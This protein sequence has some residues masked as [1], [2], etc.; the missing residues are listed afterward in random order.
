MTS[1]NPAARDVALAALIAI[2]KEGAYS[3]HV[4]QAETR[5]HSLSARDEG[6]VWR[7]VYG[8][9]TYRL[10]LDYILNQFCRKKVNQLSPVLRNLLRLA[11]YQL[12]YLDRIPD[13]AAVNEAVNRARKSAGPGMAGFVNGVLRNVIRNRDGLFKDLEP[14]TISEISLRHSHPQWMVESWVQ[15]WGSDFTGSLC[16]ANNR[17]GPLTVR[18]NT[19]KLSV[20]QFL[21]AAQEAGLEGQRGRCSDEA[22]VFAGDT[23]FSKLPGYQEG[24]FIVQG[25]ASMLPAL[26]LDVQPGQDVLDMCSAPGG[27]TTQLAQLAYSG[28]VVACDLHPS[29]LK[30]VE[31]NARRLG[32]GNIETVLGDAAFLD[33]KLNR[34]FERILVDAPCS[35]LG[36]I[37]NKPDIK[38]TRQPRD[39]EELAG[40]QLRILRAGCNLLKPGGILV[41]ST[42]TISQAENRGV[43]H[44]LLEERR[45]MQ[46]AKPGIPG[47]GT[48]FVETFPHIHD[49]D[50]FFIAKLIKVV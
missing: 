36:V 25:E 35:G 18:V 47:F 7:L 40:L 29:R 23:R 22:I 39:I 8:V 27:K 42:C 16:A 33:Q 31:E 19:G 46:L 12:V 3:G 49:L 32:L 34:R 43:I 30:L 26:C 9:V 13:F 14:G 48:E 45:D 4:L 10:S 41:Y 5:R 20:N 38:W 2:E 6:L 50:G 28:K 37:R 1:N 24:W 21:V 11:C 15:R 44:A 17:P